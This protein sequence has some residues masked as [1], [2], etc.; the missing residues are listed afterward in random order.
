M[1]DLAHYDTLG[2]RALAEAQ[3]WKAGF[4]LEQ[5]PDPLRDAADAWALLCWL[6]SKE[7]L[8]EFNETMDLSV[9]GARL[10]KTFASV[11]ISPP[12]YTD[13]RGDGEIINEALVAAALAWLDAKGEGAKT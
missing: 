3:G 8:V 5:M 4:P 12:D 6:H 1:F 10:G 13:H 7:C 9:E 11:M 2:R